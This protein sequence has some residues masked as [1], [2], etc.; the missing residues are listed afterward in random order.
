M[1]DSPT[2]FFPADIL[3]SLTRVII[4]ATVGVAPDVP[5]SID[6]LPLSML[7]KEFLRRDSCKL[8]CMKLFGRHIYALALKSG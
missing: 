4:D 6:T 1:I 2:G 3:A 5:L 7:K 8:V